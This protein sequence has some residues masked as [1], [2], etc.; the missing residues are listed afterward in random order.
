MSMRDTVVGAER[1]GSLEVCLCARPIP[2]VVCTEPATR[3][4]AIR[5][6]RRQ[7]DCFGGIHESLVQLLNV[8]NILA[9]TILC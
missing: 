4:I 8:S 2:T 6:L 7:T 3:G 9:Q 1:Q 5:E